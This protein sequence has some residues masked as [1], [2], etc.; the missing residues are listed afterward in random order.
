MAGILG[1]VCGLVAYLFAVVYYAGKGRLEVT[2]QTDP[3]KARNVTRLIWVGVIGLY[4]FLWLIEKNKETKTPQENP[5]SSAASQVE[6][7]NNAAEAEAQVAAQF[8]NDFYEKYPDLKPYGSVVDAVA[9]K[10]QA[11]G[12]RGASRE[13]IM[14]T[15][16]KAAREKLADT[17]N[18]KAKEAERK[19][20]EEK[21]KIE[22]ARA[23]M[24]LQAAKGDYY[25]LLRMGERY[26]DG[27]GVPKDLAKARDYFA[28]A[29]LR[30]NQDEAA[31]GDPHGLLRMGERY[32]DG[33]GVP[34]D[35]DKARDYFIKAIAAGEP[36]ATDE[37]SKLNQGGATTNQ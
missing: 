30:L 3:T 14:E 31:K 7:P 18:Q 2:A 1:V 13:A 17:A 34:K 29:V 24:E 32:R 6:K 11:S 10:L 36:S 9:L 12:Y 21:E 20:A 5:N 27:D 28:K 25:D 23:E 37:L 35:F 16:A 15:I 8:E 19:D 33:D 26:R 4:A 22:K